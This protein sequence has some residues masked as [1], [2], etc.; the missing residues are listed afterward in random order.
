MRNSLVMKL[1]IIFAAC[2][3]AVFLASYVVKIARNSNSLT[4]DLGSQLTSYKDTI[5]KSYKEYEKLAD[6]YGIKKDLASNNF[7]THYYLAS[8]QDYDSCAESKYKFVKDVEES[9]GE[10]NITFEVYNKCGWCKKHIV[11][12]LI[13]IDKS[14]ENPTINY[15]YEFANEID[16]GNV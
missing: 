15:N 7:S 3:G 13:E 12:Y 11:L 6:S 4:Y 10:L 8:F 16:C 9:N 1:L 14:K 5:L 2:I